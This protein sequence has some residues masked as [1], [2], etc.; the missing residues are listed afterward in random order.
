MELNQES[1]LNII[2]DGMNNFVIPFS[3][4]NGTGTT[5][6]D[7]Y[8]QKINSNGDLLWGQNGS[9]VCNA[10]W[11]QINPFVHMLP[12]QKFVFSWNDQR[13]VQSTGEVNIYLQR[14]NT[15]GT[16]GVQDI[17]NEIPSSFTLHQNYPNPFNPSTKINYELRISN[18]VSLNLYD[19]KGKL[20]KILESGYK[21]TGN[22]EVNFSAENLASGVYYYSLYSNGTLLDTKKAIVLT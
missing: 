17:N 3:M 8:A 4:N 1:P 12:N 13:Y 14:A 19:A 20:I 22:H 7:I 21:S 5:Y 2:S 15:D 11:Y 18:Y 9:L 10:N 6:W 16:V